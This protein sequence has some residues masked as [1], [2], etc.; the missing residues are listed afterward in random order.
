MSKGFQSKPKAIAP[1]SSPAGGKGWLS[2]LSLKSLK[3]FLKQKTRRK[4]AFT[5]L[6]FSV[7]VLLMWKFGKDISD[8][9]ENQMPTEKKMLEMMKEMQ[10]QQQM[11]AMGM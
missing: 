8:S 5:A 4:Q 1:A 6:T 11:G 3:S 2:F 10:A 9:I 7:A